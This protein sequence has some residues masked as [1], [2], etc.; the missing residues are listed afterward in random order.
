[1]YPRGSDEHLPTSR[2]SCLIRGWELIPNE[3]VWKAWN[4]E[5]GKTMG[6]ATR[7]K[8]EG[9]E[10]QQGGVKYQNNEKQESGERQ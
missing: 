1:M 8:E 2:S 7:R 3:N 4:Y 5:P 6:G 10:G 9:G